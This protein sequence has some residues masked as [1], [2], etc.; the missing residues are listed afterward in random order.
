MTKQLLT[1]FLEGQLY[2]IDVTK[3]QEVLKP[4]EYRTVPLSPAM[5]A[6][7]LNLRGEVVTVIDLREPLNLP[8][9]D[10]NIPRPMVVVEARGE[11]QA[12][13]IDAVGEFVQTETLMKEEPPANL[14]EELRDF[15]DGV[16]AAG[17]LIT[18]LDLE[19]ILT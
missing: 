3:T 12:L 15:V 9:A 7:V 8:K 10:T 6:G 4:Q 2:G 17:Q 18:V 1:F 14:D 16:Y 11:M 5:V 13:L 19:E